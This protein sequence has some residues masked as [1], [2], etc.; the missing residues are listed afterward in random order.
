MSNTLEI[1]GQIVKVYP[2]R[3]TVTQIPITSFVVEHKS[4]QIE[5]NNTC[6]IYC[7]V[8]CVSIELDSTLSNT[9]L[10][11]NVTVFGFLNQNSKSQLVLHVKKIDFLE[12]EGN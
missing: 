11:K 3:Y 8:F 10:Y 12:I 9:L 4:Q 6:Q 2:L 1:S 7:R 5:H